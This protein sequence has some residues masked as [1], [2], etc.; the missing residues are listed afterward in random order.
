MF[1][2]FSRNY[3][4]ALCNKTKIWQY[5]RRTQQLRTTKVF[6]TFAAWFTAWLTPVI[7]EIQLY[8]TLD[9]SDANRSRVTPAGE[10][11]VVNLRSAFNNSSTD[12]NV[13]HAVLRCLSRKGFRGYESHWLISSTTYVL[14]L[15]A[16]HRRLFPLY[17]LQ[18]MDLRR[19]DTLD[20]RTYMQRWC[21]TGA[22]TLK[23]M[24]PSP[25]VRMYQRL[26]VFALVFWASKKDIQKMGTSHRRRL[27]TTD[28]SPYTVDKYRKAQIELSRYCQAKGP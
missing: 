21:R 28:W 23:A 14:Y 3:L 16:T 20:R 9:G 26:K 27:H 15:I 12:Q 19:S 7:G 5:S 17:P 2:F 24:T 10:R 22:R 25:G 11:L 18:E 4:D 1:D 6:S 13:R 8:H